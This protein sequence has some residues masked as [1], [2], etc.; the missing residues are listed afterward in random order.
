MVAIAASEIQDNVTRPEL[1]Q[2][3]HQPEAVFEQPLRM[4]VLLGKARGGALIEEG[5]YVRAVL[6]G[7]GRDAA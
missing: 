4:A 1:G 5:P 6:Y 3:S 2:A 7:S